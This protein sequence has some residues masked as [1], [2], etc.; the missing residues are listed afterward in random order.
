[1]LTGTTPSLNTGGD[2]GLTVYSLRIMYA[3]RIGLS[4]RIGLFCRTAAVKHII[5]EAV[6]RGKRG[7]QPQ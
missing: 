1:M 2:T 6:F 7:H 5:H 4:C 3:C